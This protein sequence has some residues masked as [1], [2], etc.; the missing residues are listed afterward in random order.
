MGKYFNLIICLFVLFA[1]NGENGEQKKTPP[2]RGLV[3][4]CPNEP[5]ALDRK[6]GGVTLVFH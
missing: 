2:K 5:L 3:L 6:V 1:E 4:M